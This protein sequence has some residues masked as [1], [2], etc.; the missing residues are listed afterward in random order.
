MNGEI[1]RFI[2]AVGPHRFTTV[3]SR[4]GWFHN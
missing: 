3:A 2:L 1:E 4:L